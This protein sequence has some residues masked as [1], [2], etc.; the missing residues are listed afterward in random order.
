MSIWKAVVL[1]IGA[2]DTVLADKPVLASSTPAHHWLTAFCMHILLGYQP[3]YL[4]YLKEDTAACEV[5]TCL[6]AVHG[7]QHTEQSLKRLF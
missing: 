3:V 1:P 6:R 5:L 7:V 4:V 2:N